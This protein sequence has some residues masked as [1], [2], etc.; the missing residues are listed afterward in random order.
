MFKFRVRYHI[1]AIVSVRAMADSFM[2]V[3]R[4]CFHCVSMVLYL[5]MFCVNVVVSACMKRRKI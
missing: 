4:V 2:T 1:I 3:S 5:V